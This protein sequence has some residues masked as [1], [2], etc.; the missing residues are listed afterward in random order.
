M[1][2]FDKIPAHLDPY[3]RRLRYLLPRR[4]WLWQVALVTAAVLLI[5]RLA[6][7]PKTEDAMAKGTRFLIAD[8]IDG[9][10]DAELALRLK[11]LLIY[12]LDQSGFCV[13]FPESKLKDDR[14][15]MMRDPGAPITPNVAW[16]ICRQEKIPVFLIPQIS[17]IGSSYILS[18]R[19]GWVTPIGIKQQHVDTV[20]ATNEKELLVAIDEMGK[21]VRSLLGEP[22]DSSTSAEDDFSQL[23][24]FKPE[25]LIPFAQA[26]VLDARQDYQSEAVYLNQAIAL[27]SDFSAARMQLALCYEHLGKTGNALDQIALARA[28]AYRLAPKQKLGVHGIYFALNQQYK[29]ASVSFRQLT[30]QFPSDWRAHFDLADSYMHLGDFSEAAAELRQAIRLNDSSIESY[31]ALCMAELMNQNAGAAGEAREQI[32]AIA[33]GNPEVVFTG[34]FIDLIENNAGIATKQYR[35]LAAGTETLVKS[36]ANFL[37]AQAQIYQGH[38]QEAL[39]TLQSGI[40]EDISQ[41]NGLLQADKRIAKAN[42]WMLLGDNV[43]ALSECV[44]APDLS[45][46]VTRSA[47]LGILYAKLNRISQAQQILGRMEKAPSTSLAHY[48]AQILRGEIQLTSGQVDQAIQSFT[49]A[50]ESIFGKIPCEPLARALSVAKRWEEAAKEYDIICEHKAQML[51]PSNSCWFSGLWVSTLY[52]YAQCLEMLNRNDEARQLYRN[53]LWVLDGADVDLPTVDATRAFLK[54][55]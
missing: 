21:R 10:Q 46:D 20:R 26:L 14:R 54:R 45:T 52:S 13:P 50:K 44:G 32:A 31:I 9:T 48:H 53:Y 8:F 35:T 2:V 16:Q 1:S 37:L 22:S 41:G 12:S 4:A 7:P 24:G 40:R 49:R 38:F 51:F 19:L 39:S 5:V 27:D 34:G 33:P 11:R 23:R 42:I 18:A 17:H 43:S 47:A 15:W 25:A 55:K 3:S 6:L 29:E 36:R 28:S 30:E